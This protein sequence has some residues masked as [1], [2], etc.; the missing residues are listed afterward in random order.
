LEKTVMEH[1]AY[2]LYRITVGILTFFPTSL[3]ARFGY[4]IGRTL[5][6]L[7]CSYQQLIKTN[8]DLAFGDSLTPKEKAQIQ[9][10][11][12]ALLCS[13][14]LSGVNLAGRP[15]QQSLERTEIEGLDHLLDVLKSGRGVLA[16]M[17][18][19]SNWELVAKLSPFLFQ[20][21]CA[22]VYQ[23]LRNRRIDRH[24]RKQR[25]SEGLHLFDRRRLAGISS[26]LKSP[27]VVGVLADQ[28]AGRGGVWCPLFG[29]I[30]SSS[31]L[32]PILAKGTNAAVIS[33]AVQTTAIGRWKITFSPEVTIH[34]ENVATATAEL[35]RAIEQM[36]RSAPHDWFWSHDRWKIRKPIQLLHSRARR[37]VIGEGV[38][39][40]YRI[41]F[42]SPETQPDAELCTL[43][44]SSLL[45]GRPDAELHIVCRAALGEFWKTTL[46][47]AI[48]HPIL[49]LPLEEIAAHI[50][51]LSADA[52][53][54][55]HESPNFTRACR[56]AGVRRI[57]SPASFP[58]HLQ[59]QNPLLQARAETSRPDS[60]PALALLQHVV[61]L[62]GPNREHLDPLTLPQTNK[63]T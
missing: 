33:I 26:V 58:K 56:K 13:N 2:Y 31:P 38:I 25:K 29:R 6:P 28:N 18:H 8:L 1:L 4:A 62:G 48:V 37:E 30:T 12:F 50:A 3:V 10:Q 15:L 27:G 16:L 23:P 20:S 19:S 34:R 32:I 45:D 55:L 35:N 61:H 22:A 21:A 49:D 39:H 7:L 46:S 40:P 9:K 36:V 5:G 42:A 52:A 14:I 17:T 54:S 59:R 41:L 51:P 24:I 11:H 60:D 63:R 53:V 57:T 47:R 44:A 43:A